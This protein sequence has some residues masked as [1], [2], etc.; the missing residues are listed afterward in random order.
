MAQRWISVVISRIVTLLGAAALVAACSAQLAAQTATPPTTFS[1]T[2]QPTAQ[3]S[4]TAA[5][6]GQVNVTNS[7]L[8]SHL[9][10]ANGMSLYVLTR[11]SAGTSTCTDEC[12]QSWPPA[13]VGPGQ[14]PTAGPGVNATLGTLTRGD[15]S[16]QVTANGR[17]L[18]SFAGDSAA[19]DINGQGQ[20]GV[21]FLA[22]PDGTP[23]G[24]GTSGSP[25]ASP[26]ASDP[27]GG[28][29]GGY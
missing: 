4:A 1:P 22:A 25:A 12:A 8:G 21:W 6:G 20:G 16:I 10:G 24:A 23:L 18:Y 7:S 13:S 11:D 19:G 27:Y 17:P 9:A 2:S 3:P 26:A 14:T 29:Y 15:G 28:G 5:T